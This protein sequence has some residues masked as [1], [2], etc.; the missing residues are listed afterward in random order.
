MLS[1]TIKM[2]SITR[3]TLLGDDSARRLAMGVSFGVIIGLLPKDSL[4]VWAIGVILMI[5][6][7]NLLCAMVSGFLF[8]WV[9]FLLDP[10]THKL[11]GLMLTAEGLEPT[12][13]WLYEVPLMPWTRFNNTVVM[14]SLILG[15]V[16][17]VPVYLLS[18]RFFQTWGLVIHNRMR[19]TWIYRW[20]FAPPEHSLVE[21]SA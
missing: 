8:S 15:L 2:V 11:G 9:G 13:T 14:G 4:L 20:L 3:Q 12:W 17:A 1:D 18:F 21:E 10:F 5:T 6:T 19:K 16:L 7:A